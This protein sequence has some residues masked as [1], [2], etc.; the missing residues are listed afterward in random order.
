MSS[1]LT[2]LQASRASALDGRRLRRDRR[3]AS[4]RPAPSSPSAAAIDAGHEGARRRDRHRQRG[5]PRR[6]A[7][8]AR[9]RPGP[10]ARLF[11]GARR[12][13]AQAGV[14]VEWVEGDAEAL[15][16]EDAS[17]DRVLSTFG[18]IFA[19]RSRG[20]R[21]PRARPHLQAGRHDRASPTGRRTSYSARLI[22]TLDSYL[23][24]AGRDARGAVLAR[25]GRRRTCARSSAASSL[26]ALEPAPST[27]SSSRSTRCSRI[28][29]ST[30]AAGRLAARLDADALRPRSRPTCAPF[31]SSSMS[32]TARRGSRRSTCSSS[33][34]SPS[35]TSARTAQPRAGR[36][37]PR[38]LTG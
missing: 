15:A 1:D 2:D 14:S 16:F 13:A 37:R 10:H 12:R 4:G 30:S 8:A 22:A 26:L 19:P 32:A 9:H 5:D 7:G 17:F 31:S 20:R 29:R 24:T 6:A 33:A 25:G 21:G 34:T 23:R 11:A 18:V 36:A 38:R 28:D 27:S 3:A 35:R